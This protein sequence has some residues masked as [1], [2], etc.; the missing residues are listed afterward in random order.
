[1]LRRAYFV[2]LAGAVMLLAWTL[3]GGLATS[4]AASLGKT[5]ATSTPTAVAGG[6]GAQ[7]Y[8]AQ[9]AH[10]HGDQGKGEFEGP[11]L[12]AVLKDPASVSGIEDLVR[13]G[14][15]GMPSFAKDL[16]AA[17]ITAVAQY[18][19]S[20]FGQPGDVAPGGVLYRLNCAACHGAQAGGGAI[21]YNGRQNA[22]DLLD[23]SPGTLAAAVRG[24]PGTMPAFNAEALSDTQVVSIAKYVQTLQTL[25]NPG[26]VDT[27]HLGPVSEGA[28]AFLA[29][30]LVVLGAMWV[31][32][33]GRG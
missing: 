11:S 23:V 1:M 5:Q 6:E 30:G 12:G 13:E 18:V 22:P 24:G 15:G 25:S 2:G 27:A 20:A 16:S 26:G 7:V 3:L 14:M 19:V 33:G 29:L 8:A 28:V 32:R 17:Q 31:E 21:I 4:N 9:C 10:C